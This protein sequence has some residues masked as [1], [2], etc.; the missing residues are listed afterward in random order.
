MD[1]TRLTEIIKKK[2]REIGFDLTG[3][4][5]A[6]PFLRAFQ[7]LKERKARGKLSEFTNKD[8]K[9][10]TTP[11]L[12]LPS[13]ESIIS[14]GISYASKKKFEEDA[15]IA[16]YARGE[17]YHRIIEGKMESLIDFI[18]E[19]K[20]AA[21]FKAFTDTGP[22]LDR[23]IAHRA[24]LGWIGKNNNLINPHYG[25]F[26]VLGEI[27]T[28][29][30]LEYDEIMET[31]CGE[32]GL[33]LENCPG[34]A[35]KEPYFLDSDLCL[36][37]LTQKKGIIPDVEREKIGLSLWGCDRCQEVC[38]YNLNIPTDLHSE[39][40]PVL[41]GDFN[42]I[43]KFAGKKIP[44]EWLRSALIWRGSR[45][46]K[47][48]ALINIA[49]SGNKEYIGLL[50]KELKNNS[51]ILRAYAAWALYKLI[52]EKYRDLL[53]KMLHNEND[54]LVRNEIKKILSEENYR[55]KNND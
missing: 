12:H 45:I 49:N 10:L 47:R 22:L 13:A 48:N 1:K 33:C 11:R 21:R 14:V 28:D 41:E 38:P 39:F 24:G 40:T 17:D 35:L 26:L 2:S 43:L 29:L 37:Y 4:T 7:V 42:Q 6:E 20:P 8:I 23:E 52:P 44:D 5:S 53:E 9:L 50:K 18:K 36:S 55:G 30:H 16:L 31:G 46:L 19:Y 25:S 54:N 51:P 27:L 32:C 34:E 3:I 15:Y